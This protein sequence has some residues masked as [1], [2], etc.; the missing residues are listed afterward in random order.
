MARMY[1]LV[2]AAW[3]PFGLART[4]WHT[5]S[6]ASGRLGTAECLGVPEDGR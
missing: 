3:A 5:A 6:A 4:G 2:Y 1:F